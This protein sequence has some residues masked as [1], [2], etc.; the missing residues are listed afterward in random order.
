MIRNNDLQL[1]CGAHS[2]LLSPTMLKKRFPWVNTEGVELASF[3]KQGE[4]WLDPAAL[5]AG[6]KGKARS[7]GTTYI[8]G[9][10]I[11]FEYK[12]Q[13]SI[14]EKISILPGEGR[15]CAYSWGGET[16]PVVFTQLMCGFYMAK[17]SH[18]VYS[19]VINSGCWLNLA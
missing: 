16:G 12:D 1:E 7:L 2:I 17:L 10:V 14:S 19:R 15:D 11:G 13:V 9:Q 3:G 18:Q 8:K 4:G 6:M 5:L